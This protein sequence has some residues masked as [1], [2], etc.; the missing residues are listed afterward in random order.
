MHQ[1]VIALHYDFH[2]FMCEQFFILKS[3]CRNSTEVKESTR[4]HEEILKSLDINQ[5]S[6]QRKVQNNLISGNSVNKNNILCENTKTL[7]DKYSRNC[8]L[9]DLDVW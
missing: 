5:S 1:Q 9:E 7:M 3:C 2:Y 4:N 8:D 6:K